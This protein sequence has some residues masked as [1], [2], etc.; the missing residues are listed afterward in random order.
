MS[1]VMAVHASS[2]S[3]SDWSFDGKES[4]GNER[5]TVVY[6]T[7]KDRLDLRQEESWLDQWGK[8]HLSF[9]NLICT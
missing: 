6:R 8:E 7:E 4:E 1:V 5:N 3:M 9:G 2:S